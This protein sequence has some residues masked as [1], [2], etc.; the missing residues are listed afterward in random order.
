MRLVRLSLRYI[1]LGH[2][3]TFF[4]WSSRKSLGDRQ[5]LSRSTWRRYPLRFDSPS[6]RIAFVKHVPR[7]PCP[8]IVVR[9]H[10]GLSAL[11]GDTRFGLRHNK[12]Q[13]PTLIRYLAPPVL[14]P[15][16]R[17]A[18]PNPV[19]QAPAATFPKATPA[20]HHPFSTSYYLLSAS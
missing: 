13:D 9:A 5:R 7:P 16:S 18:P 6:H 17:L 12:S 8:I 2:L 1:N 14:H 15:A 10:E 19:L 4:S 11:P 20:R 3:P